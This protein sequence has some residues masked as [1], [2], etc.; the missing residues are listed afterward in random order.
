M[1]EASLHIHYSYTDDYNSA[2]SRDMVKCFVTIIKQQI[3][4]QNGDHNNTSLL[5]LNKWWN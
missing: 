2:A 5:L 3:M 1:I 4:L